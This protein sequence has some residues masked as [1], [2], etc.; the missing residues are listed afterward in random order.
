MD[1]IPRDARVLVAAS[2]PSS[3]L[4]D[5]RVA[6]SAYMMRDTPSMHLHLEEFEW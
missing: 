3:L 1:G 2:G 4:S 5:A 6:T